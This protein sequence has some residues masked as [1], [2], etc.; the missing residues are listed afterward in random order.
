MRMQMHAGVRMHVHA[1]VCLRMYKFIYVYMYMCTYTCHA[2]VARQS[3]GAGDL[4]S[5]V[6]LRGPRRRQ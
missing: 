2:H 6:G 5:A 1:Q 4:G 3:A